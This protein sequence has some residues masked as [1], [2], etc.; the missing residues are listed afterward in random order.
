MV[1]L[2]QAGRAG[3]LLAFPALYECM[4]IYSKMA[5]LAGLGSPPRAGCL[6]SQFP[7][8]HTFIWR[9]GKVALGKPPSAYC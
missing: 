8:L 5:G 4:H 2:P 3:R 9:R 6:V 1:R 7:C